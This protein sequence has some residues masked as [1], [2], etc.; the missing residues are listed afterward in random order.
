MMED[1]WLTCGSPQEMLEFLGDRVSERKLRLFACAC[2]RRIWP[3]IR[4]QFGRDLVGLGES[5]ADGLCS[6]D[7]LERASTQGW[8]D[9]EDRWHSQTHEAASVAVLMTLARPLRIEGGLPW[10]SAAWAGEQ[11]P[12]DEEAAQCDLVACVFGNPFRPV[13]VDPAWPR[14]NSGAVLGLAR[15]SYDARLLS[16]GHL[17]P[18]RLAVLADALEE[19][20]CA[21]AELMG[22]LREPGPHV[23]GCFA[24][25]L[26]LD[27]E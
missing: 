11:P 12:A 6:A 1:D 16:S 26:L 17:D 19:A 23:R 25:D 5:Y 8:P 13:V 7:E 15:A 18:D 14:W 20:G 21:D 10:E 9:D 4:E 24:V 22:H 2:C 27:K 3:A